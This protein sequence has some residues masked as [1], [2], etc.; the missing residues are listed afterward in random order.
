MWA[1]GRKKGKG[2][3]LGRGWAKKRGGKRDKER[4]LRVVFRLF[5]LLIFYLNLISSTH[6]NQNHATRMDATYTKSHFI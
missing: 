5:E 4:R 1:V 3:D 6:I 2:R